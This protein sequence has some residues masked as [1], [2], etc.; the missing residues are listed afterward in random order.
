MDRIE[1][2]TSPA[3]AE[4]PTAN[5]QSP[6]ANAQPSVP[7]AAP[8][9]GVRPQWLPEKFQS[10]ED[11]AKAYSELESRFTQANQSDTQ[12]EKAVKAAGLTPEDI[13]PMS[14]EFATTGQLSEKSYKVFESRGIPRQMVDAFVAGQKA[15]ADAQVSQVYSATGGQEQYQEMI[16]WA[17]E[18][19][20][21]DEIE[22]FD[23]L[24][25]SGNQ[26]SILM[27]VRGLHARYSSANG[28]PNLLQGTSA[29]TGSSAYRSLAELTSA[30]K[31]P[32]YKSDP[33]YRKDVE[34]RLRVSDVF[35]GAR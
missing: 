26:A 30:M 24:I 27:A 14:E 15:V 23:N 4:A 18:N 17:G 32:R 34:D 16:S 12:V 13:A 33:A 29:T 25:E 7:T 11:L 10:P 8:T 2:R 21:P 35:G 1:I 20:P 28:R 19:L 9:D 3:P 22:A 31:D 5:A 6:T